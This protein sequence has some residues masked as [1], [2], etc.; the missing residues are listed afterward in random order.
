MANKCCL[1]KKD[2]PFY[3]TDYA[4]SS[5]LTKKRV[6]DECLR[7]VDT[8]RKVSQ[9]GDGEVYYNSRIKLEERLKSV[10]DQEVLEFCRVIM[11]NNEEYFAEI[12]KEQKELEKHLLST[13]FNFE[14]YR[15]IKYNGIV[16]G[17]SVMGTGFLSEFSAGLSDF[18]GTE[19]EAF[20]EKLNKARE[21]AIKKLIK[22]SVQKG[23]NATIGIN[24]DYITFSNNMIG[25]VAN[26]TSVIVEIN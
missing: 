8:L 26:G 15:I 25:V 9:I 18:F 14:G 6:C 19:S 10:T 3:A 1:C 21:S 2:I 12:Q 4:L 11:S 20:S 7:I 16:N 24:F 23:G 22:V 17:E 13:S 5:E